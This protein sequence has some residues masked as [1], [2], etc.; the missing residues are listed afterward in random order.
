VVRRIC[1]AAAAGADAIR[2]PDNRLTEPWHTR[3][4]ALGLYLSGHPL[5][6][7]MMRC[8][9]SARARRPRAGSADRR[10]TPAAF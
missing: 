2:L 3:R 7:Y 8:A 9:R 1:S 10:R 4:D 6:R 5:D